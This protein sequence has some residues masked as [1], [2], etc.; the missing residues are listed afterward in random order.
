MNKEKILALARE[1][2]GVSE[3]PPG[4]N[5]VLYNTDYYG[6]AVQGTGFPWCCVFIWWLFDRSGLSALFCG[7]QRT[8]FC[9]FVVQYAREHGQWVT[10]EYRSG[11]LLL[12][13]W[14]NDGQA[15]HIGLC[16]SVSGMTA[17]TIEGTV[18]ESVKR[19]T[20]SL[21]TVLGAYRP[22]YGDP[23]S[24]ADGGSSPAG[25]AGDTSSGA[26]APPSPQGEGFYTVKSGDTLWGIAEKFY[27]NGWA[28]PLI[29]SANNLTDSTI[30]P[31][32]VLTIPSVSGQ[33]T[34]AKVSV[35]LT[36]K[37]S[38]WREI[39][40]RAT[41]QGLTPAEWLELI[42]EGESDG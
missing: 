38:T 39:R 7:G 10:E 19:M 20:R 42:V 5:N 18:G 28:Y 34:E 29:I 24:A 33:Q 8:A 9:P 3:Q 15:D 27:G 37:E 14:D 30:Y 6:G 36:M 13:D 12:Y 23:P 4:R 22:E 21:V 41:S 16:E 35:Y 11:D 40:S 2:L 25:G 31:G 26:D 1:Q 17:V 32:Q